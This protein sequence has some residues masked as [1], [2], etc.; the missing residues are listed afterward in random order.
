MEFP[1]NVA[2]ARAVSTLPHGPDYWYEPKF[3]GHRMIM[4]RTEESVILYA[5]SGRVVTSN[6]MDLAVAGME[7]RPATVLDGEAVVWRDGHLDFGAVQSRAAS[8]VARAR[9]L[10]GQ[11][12]AAY[13]C[14]DVLHHPDPAIGDTRALPY[15][16]RRELLLNLLDGIGSPIQPVPATD[17]RTVAEDWYESLQPMGIEGVVAKRGTAGYPSGRRAW[18]KVRHADT[19]E[20]RVVGF[21]GARRRPR[22][23]VLVLAGAA[24]PRMS[25]RLDPVLAAR[26]GTALLDAPATGQRR[27]HGEPYTG[28]ETDLV[29]EVLAG[30][31][32]HG[33]LTVVRIR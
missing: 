22:N 1:V 2:L 26:I 21:T 3:D 11:H 25:V 20:A 13:A 17:D 8:S 12:P 14:W 18:V 24:R 29:V 15:T 6:W 28:L 32:R 9:F 5:R 33:T 16:R 30:T 19:A 31:G 23:P 27:T 7:L 10:A 4:R